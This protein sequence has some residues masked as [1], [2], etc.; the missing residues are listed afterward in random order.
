MRPS[1]AATWITEEPDKGSLHVRVCGGIWF[2]N[3]LDS[4]RKFRQKSSM[5]S[6]RW[7]GRNCGL[8]PAYLLA[9]FSADDRFHGLPRG[10]IRLVPTASS[11]IHSF[12]A[13]GSSPGPK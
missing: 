9:A 10:P 7:Q 4:T 5:F 11:S 8:V 1:G 12:W 6:G 13:C 3:E 2:S